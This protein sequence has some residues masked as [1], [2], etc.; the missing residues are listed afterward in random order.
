MA[1]LDCLIAHDLQ[2]LGQ[3]VAGA[4]GDRE[5][6]LVKEEGSLVTKK[7]S[8]CTCHELRLSTQAQKKASGKA[9]KDHADGELRGS[10]NEKQGEVHPLRYSLA[11]F[12]LGEAMVGASFLLPDSELTMWLTSFG[13]ALSLTGLGML[14][15]HWERARDAVLEAFRHGRGIH[16]LRTQASR[17]VQA[18]RRGMTSGVTMH[19]VV[20][21]IDGRGQSHERR[22]GRWCVGTSRGRMLRQ[23]AGPPAGGERFRLPEGRD[24]RPS[25]E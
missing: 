20:S 21:N 15:R 1:R 13:W 7:F 11:A 17:C 9:T 14:L 12:V 24:R 23:R 8:E 10:P 19:Q 16:F 4:P 22:S 25:V 5:I 6:Q 3:P 18:V 2:S